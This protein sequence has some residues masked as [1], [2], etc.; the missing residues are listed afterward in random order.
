MSLVGRYT[1]P[2]HIFTVPFDTGTISMMAVI[3]KQGGNVVLVKDLED[4]TLGD[5]TVSCTLTEEETSLFKP[6]PQ[7][8]I[9][10]RVGIGNARLNSNILNV[11]VADVLKDGLL[12]DI[13]GGDTKRFFRLHS[14]PLKTSFK[15][16]FHLRHLLL[17]L[18]SAAWLA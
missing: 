16:L 9:Q 7:V 5:K 17:Q 13:A 12:D 4:C 15:P 8:Q 6:N 3:Y 2:T 11:S 1:T 14:N 10:L 18:H